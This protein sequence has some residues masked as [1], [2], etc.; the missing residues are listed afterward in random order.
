MYAALARSERLF[1]PGDAVCVEG[2]SP[3]LDREWLFSISAYY[4]SQQVVATSPGD[5][6]GGGPICRRVKLAIGRDGSA[7]RAKGGASGDASFVP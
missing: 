2:P 4:L 1:R 5:G 3:S 6:T 7:H